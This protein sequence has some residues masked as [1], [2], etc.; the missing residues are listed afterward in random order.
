MNKYLIPK[1]PKTIEI[2]EEEPENSSKLYQ[3]QMKI[4]NVTQIG[5]TLKYSI[6]NGFLSILLYLMKKDHSS[7]F[8][9][10]RNFCRE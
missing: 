1:I 8:N 9:L 10:Q 4:Q 5:K 3:K 2:S 6:M 7:L